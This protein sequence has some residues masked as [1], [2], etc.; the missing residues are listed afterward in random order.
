MNYIDIKTRI[1]YLKNIKNWINNNKNLIYEA[2]NKDLNKSVAEVDNT[3]L[4]GIYEELKIAL[5]NIKKWTKRKRSWEL[6][7][8]PTLKFYSQAFPYGKVLIISPWNYP[9]SLTI[10]P[11]ISALA[12]GNT[13]YLKP[14]EFSSNTSNL[15]KEMMEEIFDKEVVE[16][17]LGEK[18]VTQEL[19]QRDIKFLFF[20][21]NT[22]VGRILYQQAAKKLI[23]CVL[24]L[25]G[26]CPT[27]VDQTTD[28]K[29]T[30]KR[31]I[32]G[33]IM[34]SG[35]TC[36]APD[37]I[38]VH[39]SIKEKLIKE[40]KN[41]YHRIYGKKPLENKSMPAIIS[42][43]HLNRIK[44]LGLDIKVNNKR[45]MEL[46]IVENSSFD[47]KEMENEL[48]CPILPIISYQN[49]DDIIVEINERP[50]PLALYVFSKDKK[51]IEHIINS[52]NSGGVAINDT[53]MHISSKKLPFGGVGN[54]GIGGYHGYNGFKAFSHFRTISKT[55]IKP[56]FE[57]RYHFNKNKEER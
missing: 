25:G 29:T 20:T 55:A 2:L 33:K 38:C 5:K 15:I 50:S 11:L 46:L 17:F 23:P 42:D 31:I 27:I 4:D 51:N 26:K 3:E 56:D 45:Q 13:A 53:I 12:A 18:E 49:I 36:V 8:L 40:I 16:V 14:S 1:T 34:N 30:A 21:G 7:S 57:I 43:R 32:F 9:F 52:I 48:F 54:S 10:R 39:E 44:N 22:E 41:E 37:Y 6:S 19:M 28:I 35:Q 47:S 24:E